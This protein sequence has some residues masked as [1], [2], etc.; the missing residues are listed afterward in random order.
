MVDPLLILVLLAPSASGLVMPGKVNPCWQP[1]QLSPRAVASR[2]AVFC[3]V[4]EQ[5]AAEVPAVSDEVLNERE[6]PLFE[7]QFGNPSLM[8]PRL[9]GRRAPRAR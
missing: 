2:A 5:P 8:L 1:S 4:D 6:P 7:Q 9:P 3:Q